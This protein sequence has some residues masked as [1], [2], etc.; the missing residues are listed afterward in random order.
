MT[1]PTVPALGK[2]GATLLCHHIPLS[3]RERNALRH[4]APGAPRAG[5]SFP[6]GVGPKTLAAVESRGWAAKRPDTTRRGFIYSI[7]SE[8][9][10]VLDA[11]DH[12]RALA[13]RSQ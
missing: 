4:L 6:P 11:D 1:R 13:A 8:G 5:F 10:R 12:F 9:R 3:W 2:Q 7:T